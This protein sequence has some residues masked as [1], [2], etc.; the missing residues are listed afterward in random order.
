M[1]R[2]ATDFF[3]VEPRHE[4]VHAA[5]ENWARWVRNRQSGGKQGPIW[6]LGKPPQH[7]EAVDDA[8]QP[9]DSLAAADM[10]KRVGA[11]PWKHCEAIRWSYVYRNNP[12]SKAQALGM[13][14]D[15]LQELV[16]VG[17]TMLINRGKRDE[18]M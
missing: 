12:R 5:L 10:E 13:S 8:P 17:R 18:R 14:L 15:G 1:R 16:R 3:T 9:V 6:R 11:L 2:E 7:W 4:A